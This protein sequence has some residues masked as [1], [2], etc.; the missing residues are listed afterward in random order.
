MENNK[1]ISYNFED[2]K[3]YRQGLMSREEMHAFEKASMEDPF[4]SDALEGYMQADMAVADEH[5]GNIRESV[6]EQKEEKEQAVVVNMPKRSFGFMRI[7]AML[8]VI[9]GAGLITYKIV[10]NKKA[11][12]DGGGGI[13]KLTPQDVTPVTGNTNGSVATDSNTGQGSLKKINPVPSSTGVVA[14]NKPAIDAAKNKPTYSGLTKDKENKDANDV[15]VKNAT[16]KDKNAAAMEEVVT[17]AAIPSQRNA[18]ANAKVKNATTNEIRGT[19]L[20]PN[21]E[22]LANANLRVENTRKEIATDNRGNFSFINKDTLVN[23]TITNGSYANTTVQLKANENNTINLGT[24]EM[25]QDGAFEKTV[26]VIGLGTKKTR[27]SDTSGNKPVNGWASFQDY[28]AKTVGIKLDSTSDEEDNST[29]IEFFV[30]AR[31]KPKDVKLI[32]SNDSDDVRTKEIVEA[33]KQGPKWAGK[34]KKMRI[35]IKY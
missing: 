19:I 13:A 22:P 33:V 11:D 15:A 29:E 24:I 9:I 5:L 6:N 7:A 20:M 25:K 3:R 10:D 1:S 34:N 14:N 28:V 12:S 21:N 32:T 4:L 8:I 30:D 26:T 31:G 2:I 23:A 18:V 16:E 17:T 27:V 35:V